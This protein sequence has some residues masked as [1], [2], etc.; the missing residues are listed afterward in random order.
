M[1]SVFCLTTFL[2]INPEPIILEIVPNILFGI[3]QF[4]YQLFLKN[5]P[6][7]P[8]LINIQTNF[9]IFAED[10]CRS[11]L[12]QTKEGREKGGFSSGIFGSSSSHT[13]NIGAMAIRQL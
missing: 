11:R 5:H 1:Y 12:K 3:S 8:Q 10:V 13:N 9:I 7:I 6:I 2:S 4:T